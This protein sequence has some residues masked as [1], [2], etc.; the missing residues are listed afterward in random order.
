MTARTRWLLGTALALGIVGAGVGVG[1][2]QSGPSDS[3]ADPGEAEE[4][5]GADTDMQ[6]TGEDRDRAAAAALEA[7]GGGMVT[8]V[9]VG[10]DGS[11]YGVEIRLADG[12]HVEVQLDESFNVTGTE[13]DDE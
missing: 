5:E 12:T 3:H 13:A 11:A 6:L 7:V 8:E 4:A 1:L 10:D 9:E 2:A